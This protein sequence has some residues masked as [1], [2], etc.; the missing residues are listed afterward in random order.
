MYGFCSKQASAPGHR[1]ECVPPGSPQ[2]SRSAGDPTSSTLPAPHDEH[3]SANSDMKSLVICWASI[4]AAE[5]SRCI[6]SLAW[7]DQFRRSAIVP[8]ICPFDKSLRWPSSPSRRCGRRFDRARWRST[9]AVAAIAVGRAPN[10]RWVSA[11]GETSRPPRRLRGSQNRPCRGAWPRHM[12]RSAALR[13]FVGGVSVTRCWRRCR[14]LTPIRAMGAEFERFGDTRNDA[15]GD[16]NR[17]V[18]GD[19]GQ[20]DDEFVAAEAAGEIGLADSW[21][22]GVWLPRRERR[23]PPHVPDPSLTALKPSRS[24]QN[25]VSFEFGDDASGLGPAS[26]SANSF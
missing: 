14:C 21:R 26:S 17:F 7:E 23:R 15:P 12:A 2:A 16:G 11:E 9:H 4:P 25:T 6:S 22:A 20:Q 10:P 3:A 19:V 24:R 8:K 13:Q 18:V 5:L 1:R